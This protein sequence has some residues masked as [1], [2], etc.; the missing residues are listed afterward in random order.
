MK[1][2]TKKTMKKNQS[3]F[4]FFKF[5]PSTVLAATNVL[6]IGGDLLLHFVDC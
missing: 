1:K 3:H 4:F 5:S 2:E 6:Q